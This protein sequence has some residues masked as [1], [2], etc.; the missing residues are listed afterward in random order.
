MDNINIDCEIL[1]FILENY[2]DIV[3][4][5]LVTR[6]SYIKLILNTIDGNTIY[7]NDSDEKDIE[8][9]IIDFFKKILEKQP[10]DIFSYENYLTS[11]GSYN[12][13]FFKISCIPM[14]PS[15]SDVII[16]FIPNE[17]GMFLKSELIRII[18]KERETLSTII[19]LDEIE[20]KS[21]RRM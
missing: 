21:I 13:L 14:Y 19:K 9:K 5:V 7:I 15:G 17:D 8:K 4:I 3:K 20:N 16:Q 2:G 11:K 1:P 10:S 18:K 12:D 6:E